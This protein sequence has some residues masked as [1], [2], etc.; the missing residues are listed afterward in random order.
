MTWIADNLER[1]ARDTR[2]RLGIDHQLRPDMI[3][4]IIKAKHIGLIKDYVRVPDADMPNDEARYDPFEK[5]LYVRESTFCAANATHQYS[6]SERQR[7]RF[8]IAHE[9]GHVALGHRHVRHRGMTTALAEGMVRSIRNE[10]YEA[11]KFAAA[12]LAPA[13]LAG[14]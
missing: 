3:T 8:T 9:I 2:V 13:Y 14:I 7:A 10:E 11:N 12:F 4:V 5:V 6:D 1:A